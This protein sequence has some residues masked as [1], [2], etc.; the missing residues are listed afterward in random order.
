MFFYLAK[1]LWMI[2]QPSAALLLLLGLGIVLI[3]FRAFRFGGALVLMSTLGLLVAGFLPLGIA[4]TL[5]LEDRFPRPALDQPPDGIVVIGGGIDGSI[6]KARGSIGVVE[7]GGRMIEAV[8]LAKRFPN[9]RLVFSGGSNSLFGGGVSEAIAA[10]AFFKAFDIPDS[11]VT[12]EGESRDTAENAR[13]AKAVVQPKPGER[14]LLL[15]AAW[16][17][18][19]AVGCFRAVGWPVIAFLTDYRTTGDEDLHHLMPRPSLGLSMV[20]VATREWIGLLMY[21]LVGR[22]DALFPAP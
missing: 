15:T 10:R 1:I 22:T 6:D 3:G 11:R 4:L 2:A 7:G 18:P 13:F 20:D 17:M 5:P 9:A 16:H 14:W 12:I 19:R 21:R 8:L